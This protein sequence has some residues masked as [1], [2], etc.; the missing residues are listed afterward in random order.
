MR[1]RKKPW[2]KAELDAC[3]YFIKTPEQIRGNWKELFANAA[4]ISLE[5]GC[6]KGVFTAQYGLQNPDRNIIAI[7]LISDM[8]GVA[9]RN[10]EKAYTENGKTC[11]NIMLTAYDIE[12]IGNIISPDDR[13]SNII[14]YFCNPWPKPSHRRRRLTHPE[15]LNKYREF[16]A[17]GGIVEFK[18]DDKDLFFDS[19]K[20]FPA[21]GFE[22][23]ETAEYTLD[24]VHLS[25]LPIIS[26]HERKYLDEGKTI[27]YCKA[28]KI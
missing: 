5:L 25:P 22:I 27:R 6:G 18:T 11:T 23:M 20:Y 12:R 19:L 28:K 4:P 24:T 17:D 14:I 2:A 15:Q 7:D 3:P 21:A 16:L 26:E 10:I 13:I 9:R 8:L 1:I